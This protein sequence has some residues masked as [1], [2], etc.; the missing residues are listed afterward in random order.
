MAVG[1]YASTYVAG[2]LPTDILAVDESGNLLVG[3]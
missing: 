3:T 1:D 2:G